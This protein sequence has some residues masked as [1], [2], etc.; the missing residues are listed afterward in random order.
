MNTPGSPRLVPCPTCG[1]LAPFA[2]SNRWRPFCSERC[3][4]VDL[5]AWASERF[6]VPAEAPP[7]SP[8]PDSAGDGGPTPEQPPRH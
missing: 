2:P 5:G 4:S 1:T 7:D 3:R 6:R 8:L